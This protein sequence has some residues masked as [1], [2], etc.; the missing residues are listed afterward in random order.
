MPLDRK[1]TDSPRSL[2]DR[3][4]PW[5]E[6]MCDLEAF[7]SHDYDWRHGRLPSYTYFYNDDILS[8]QIEAYSA[9]IVENGLGE[10]VAFKSLSL[11]LADIYNISRELFHAPETAG[12]TFTGGGTESLFLAV[13]TCR[14]KARASRK[15]PFGHYNVVAG[16]AAHA[17]LDKAGHY[18]DVEVRRTPLD[19]EY[20]TTAESLTTAIDDRTIMLFASAPCYPYGVFDRIDEISKLAME[21]DLWL[22]V[23][24]CWGGFISP[25]AESLGYRIPRWDMAVPGVTSL[26][27]DIHKFGYAVKGASLLLYRDAKLQDYEYFEFAGWARGTY[28]TS[29]ATGS[30]SAGAISSAWAL[31]QYL[32][33]KGYIEATDAAMSATMRLI[34]GINSIPG[35][36]VVEPFGEANLFNFV[37]TDADVD[38][39]AIA[40]ILDE[41]GWMRGRMRSPISI[42]Q[43]V[44]A[45]HLPYVEEYLQVVRDAVASVRQSGRTGRYSERTY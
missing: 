11:M 1:E 5:R 41:K 30:R 4:R 21:R 2:P 16:E 15:E 20:R 39:M 40:D 32:G 6:I 19:A 25:F 9:Y 3:G 38:L 12:A 31:M 34:S 23:D 35:L 22:H 10:G 29:T 27:A 45:S 17:T 26:S 8:K 42:H 24:G 44:T 43:G 14:D 18:L 28:R 13:K 37:S 7:K 33:K 36:K